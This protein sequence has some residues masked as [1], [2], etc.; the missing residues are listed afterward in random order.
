MTTI[1][2][3][4]AADSGLGSESERK[5]GFLGAFFF[6]EIHGCLELLELI[7]SELAAPFLSNHMHRIP[8]A[9][10]RRRV[11]EIKVVELFYGHAPEECGGEDVDTL[12]P[13]LSASV[14][15]FARQAAYLCLRRR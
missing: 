3:D 4:Q 5:P 11:T 1:S 14:R 7:G 13:P 2:R 12:G 8:G 6:I 9:A 15:R 10:Q